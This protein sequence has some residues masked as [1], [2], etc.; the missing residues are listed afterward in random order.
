MNDRE[1]IYDV[2]VDENVI[3]ED[4]ID[5]TYVSSNCLF[6]DVCCV[7]I[8]IFKDGAEDEEKQKYRDA[9]PLI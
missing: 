3:D 7:F 1:T 5:R 2:N 4:V 8:K 9:L 6:S